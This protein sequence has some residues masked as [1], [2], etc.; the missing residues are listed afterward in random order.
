MTER[1]F[2]KGMPLPESTLDAPGI[3]ADRDVNSI[4]LARVWICMLLASI[5]PMQK[6]LY[7]EGMLGIK[8]GKKI[9]YDLMFIV[10]C[11]HGR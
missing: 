5:Y 6:Q 9:K 10:I 2:P 3:S 4:R 7:F 11:G 8:H 1:S